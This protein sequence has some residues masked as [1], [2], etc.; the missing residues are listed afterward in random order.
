VKYQSQV[1]NELEACQRIIMPLMRQ[2]NSNNPFA[3]AM[4]GFDPM[5][6]MGG[7][8]PS[9]LANMD[10]AAMENIMNMMGMDPS[11][12]Q[13]FDPSMMQGFDPNMMQQMMGGMGGMGGEHGHPAIDPLLM[14]QV[15]EY[16]SDP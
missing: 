4:G 16:T 9:M 14:Q 11:M 1:R 3:A 10:P 8:D 15:G 12:L 5:G 2:L 7:I 13:G 6:G